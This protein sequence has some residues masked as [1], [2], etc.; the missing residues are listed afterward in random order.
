MNERLGA[1]SDELM[2]ERGMDPDDSG[3]SPEEWE[4]VLRALWEE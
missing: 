3:L 2:R 4:E 1:L